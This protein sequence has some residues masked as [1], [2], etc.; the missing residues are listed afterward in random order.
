MERDFEQR[1]EEKESR[2]DLSLEEMTHRT[3]ELLRE[4][5]PASDEKFI[6]YML[7]ERNE[8]NSYFTDIARSI[9]RT[10]FEQ[11]FPDNDVAG[12]Q[13]EYNPY[14]KQSAFF[15]TI[16]TEPGEPAGTVR[17]IRNG[18]QG[19][20]TLVDLALFKNDPEYVDRVYARYGITDKNTCWDV[21]TAAV[22]PGYGGGEVSS[23]IYRGMWVASRI[24]QI[25][26]LFSVIDKKP[27]ELMEF[28]GFPFK[29]LPEVDWMPYAGSKSSLPVH[30]DA[31]A[32]EE[33]VRRKFES[34]TDEEMKIYVRPFFR[35]LGYGDNDN[36]L[37]LSRGHR[38]DLRRN[39]LGYAA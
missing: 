37:E 1:F 10:V 15:L 2:Y 14:E 35:T 4:R 38:D 7:D 20:K 11:R 29:G 36:A 13:R 39:D 30:G 8:E 6:C 19:F 12:M 33:S 34:I 16:D 24:E 32:F 21:A 31:P 5:E 22:L 27:F 17:I 9:E 26:H 3:R 18:N 28:L 23:Q 25:L